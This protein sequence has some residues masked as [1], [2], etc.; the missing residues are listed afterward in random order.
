MRKHILDLSTLFLCSVIFFSSSLVYGNE[1]SEIDHQHSE[2]TTILQTYTK[3]GLVNYSSLKNEGMEIFDSYLE[4]LSNTCADDYMKWTRAQR[5]AFWVNAYNGFTVKLILNE[6]PL[7]SIRDI[8][9]FPLAAFRQKFIPMDGLKGG[10][11]SLN[12]IE[13]KTLRADFKEP[14]IHFGLVC[15]SIGCPPLIDRAY[16]ADTLD[17]QLEQQTKLFLANKERNYYDAESSTLYLSPIF[18][19]FEEDFQLDGQTVSQY[20]AQYM[21]G[22]EATDPDVSIEYTH[23]DWSLNELV[24]TK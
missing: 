10:K 15:A 11:I 6:Y 18:K 21:E 5:I 9:F 2:W 7:E 12:D 24:N 3:D 22:Y 23:Y 8:G 14:R 13:H 4:K 1:C 19:W 16:T 20:A 17:Q